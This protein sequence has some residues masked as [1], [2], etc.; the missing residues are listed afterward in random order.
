MEEVKVGNEQQELIMAGVWIQANQESIIAFFK[1]ADIPLE[2]VFSYP[3]S[4]C[5][6]KFVH[7]ND[8]VIIAL[9]YTQDELTRNI[10]DRAMYDAICNIKKRNDEFIKS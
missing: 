5:Y 7:E 2:R 4:G 3:P 8:A 6:A 9:K 10:L 1:D